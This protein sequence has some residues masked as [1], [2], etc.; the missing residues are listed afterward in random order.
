[1]SSPIEFSSLV[2]AGPLV[3][4]GRG[5]EGVVFRVPQFGDRVYKEFLDASYT[6][7]DMSALNRLIELQ[8]RWTPEEKSWLVNRTVWPERT[9]IDNGRLKGFVMPGI[10]RRFIRKHG[11]RSNPKTV[12]CEWNYLSLRTK[13]HNNPNIVTEVPKVAPADAL[14]LVH[15]LAKT[16]KFLHGHGVI[17]GDISGKNLLWTDTPS[18]Q[19]MIIDCD[20]FRIMGEGGVAS[21]K[22]SPDWDDPHLAGKPTSQESDIYKLAIAAFRAIWASGT[23]RPS[24][25][26]SGLPAVP[27][28]VPDE[29]RGL[30]ER[31]MEPTGRPSAEEWEKVLA[32]P[33]IFR[34]RPA[35]KMGSS[36]ASRSSNSSSGNGIPSGSPRPI[37]KMK[38]DDLQ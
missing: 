29:I 19:V 22:Q 16:I 21:P 6:S 13:F 30:I 28:G 1:M 4:L 2:S 26:S 33:A 9:V 7:P 18:Y 12:L 5:G 38:R 27:K 32:M 3:E 24:T 31:S 35:V 34:G 14:A 8:N 15:D 23:D 11:I 36:V 10:Q 25:P 37:L 20:S 17:I